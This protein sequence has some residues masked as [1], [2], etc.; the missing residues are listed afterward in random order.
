[1]PGLTIGWEYLTGYAVATDPSNRDRAEWPPHP[2]RVFMALAAAWF[3]TGEDA[4][5][6]DALRWLENLDDKPELRLPSQDAV[7]ERS[8]VTVYVPVNDVP[9]GK[10][11]GTLQSVSGWPRSKRPRTFPR[12]WV[13]D[14]A[15]VLQWP[16]ADGSEHHNALDRLC[17]KVTRIGHSSS[18]VRMWVADDELAV[19]NDEP[20]EHYVPDGGLPEV[21]TRAVSAGMLD[22]LAERFG[23]GPRQRRAE[24]TERIASLKA[25]KKSIK[26]KG[27]KDRKAEI[28]EQTE[29]LDAELAITPDKS[30]VRP[31][32]GLWTGYRRVKPSAEPTLSHSHFD[33]D[34]LVLKQIDGPRLPVVSTLAVTRALRGTV[35]KHVHD[36]LCGCGKWNER[37]PSP[38]DATEC[39]E[40]IPAWVS[41]HQPNGKP[42]QADDGHLACVPLPFVG[43]EHADGHLLGVA[44]VFP[45]SV[46]RRERGQVLGKLLVDPTGQPKLVQLKLRRLGIWSIEKCDWSESG[47]GLQ[48]ETWTANQAKSPGATTWASVTPVVLD[49]FPKSIRCKDRAGW[50]QE[51]VEIIVAACKRIDLPEPIGIDIDTT[52]WHCGS[53]RAVGKRRRLRGHAELKDRTDAALGDGFPPY[54]L[55]GVNAP[56]PQVHVW[57]QFAEPVLGPVL[58]GAGRYLGYGLCKPWESRR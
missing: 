15:C 13:G 49:R 50:T 23:A 16:D 35:L 39:Y 28:D 43:H 33:T 38:P 9:I 4:E 5:E 10:K 26:G 53:P 58:L 55:K 29:P 56:R 32:I 52:S 20:V 54:L 21:H 31:T 34:L 24:L 18:L 48:P 19:Q 1:M 22:M 57:L 7:F 3:E 17:S 40:K 36:E 37:I 2:A 41:G 44:L 45:H 25:S 11:P 51:V 12:V 27:S 14:A 46:D 30:P 6:G 42:L 8:L 47:Q